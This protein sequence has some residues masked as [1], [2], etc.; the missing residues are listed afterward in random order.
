MARKTS[1]SRQV[2]VAL[3]AFV[4]TFSA[5]AQTAPGAAADA[6]ANYVAKP[7][8][9]FEW[10]VQKRYSSPDAA[11]VELHFESQRWQGEP[12][13]HQLL[14][15]RPMRIADEGRAIFIIGGG[16]WRDEYE[17]ATAE[18]PLPEDAGLFV[19]IAKVLKTPV[20]VLGQVPYQPL[21]GMTED[22]LI[23]HTFERYLTTGDP[24][25]PLLLPMVKSV[26]RAFDASSAASEREWG[27]P[28][29]R[30]TVIGG[31]K[32]GWTTWLT[33]AVDPR[34]TAIA[35]IVIDALNMER[36]FPHQT[37]AWGAP[38][39]SI[40]PYTD[41]GLDRIL[42]S[43]QGADL[44]Q[45]VDPYAY[46][47]TL[48]LPKLVILATNDQY[49]PLDSANLYF[50]GLREPKYLLY[51]P[52]EPHSVKHYGN[53]VRGLRALHEASGG[54]E[55]LPRVDWEY[56]ATADGLTLCIDAKGARSLHVWRAD[57]ADRDFR[58]AQW[59]DV[60]ETRRS[61]GSFA[62]ERPAAGYA[63]VF[64][65]MRFG[66]AL[67]AFSLSTGLTVLAAADNPPYG[68]EPV[69]TAD[70]CSAINSAPLPVPTTQPP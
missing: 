14:L 21:F 30:F 7:D 46:R 68:T 56:R 13:K 42:A 38:S 35:P 6:L 22:R 24:E 51:L 20:V 66:A 25:W 5:G 31:S 47:D 64:G 61:R 17:A 60:V 67:K 63:A 28:L 2:L 37:E 15:I 40:Q 45:I 50:G 48:T 8:D 52:N 11:V 23:A 33:A 58:D 27:K 10:H 55:P 53:V 9:A 49:F 41:L 1:V 43:P 3:L 59:Q 12:W 36:H 18:E 29:D 26:V 4:G 54:G 34:V 69:S 39:A 44:R 16:R 57:S 65:E 70:V 62:L 32:R 19:A